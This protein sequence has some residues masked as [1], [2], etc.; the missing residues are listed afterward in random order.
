[1]TMKLRTIILVFFFSMFVLTGAVCFEAVKTAAVGPP[2]GYE[3]DDTGQVAKTAVET[4][5]E[6]FLGPLFAKLAGSGA[7]GFLVAFGIARYR[8]KKQDAMMDGL[9]AAL[10]MLK[11]A[12][13]EAPDM[14]KENVVS[15]IDTAFAENPKLRLA[16]DAWYQRKKSHRKKEK[17]A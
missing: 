3:Y 13:A 11:S 1:M 8:K 7:A 15:A 9:S 17:A 6:P 4:A 14:A 16:V 2:S 10:D 12:T 5:T